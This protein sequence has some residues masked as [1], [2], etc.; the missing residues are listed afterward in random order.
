[1]IGFPLPMSFSS[2]KF[3]QDNFYYRIFL[4]IVAI[5]LFFNFMNYLAYAVNMI[6]YP[7][8]LDVGEGLIINRSWLLSRG[9]NIYSPID[10]EPYFV[11]NY[12]PL[13]ETVLAVLVKI[14]GPKIM[15][16]RVL[17]AGSALLCGYFIHKIVW[18]V[19]KKGASSAVAGLLFFMS[20]WLTS[21]SVLCRI[22]VFA[23]MFV[24]AGLSFITDEDRRH[25]R[26]TIILSGLCFVAALFSRQSMIAAPAACAAAYWFCREDRQRSLKLF[27]SCTVGLAVLIGVALTVMT[28]GE[29]FRHSVLYTMG[30]YE[31]HDFVRW[32]KEYL[33][34]HGM[35]TLVSVLGAVFITS[36]KSPVLSL[37]W[38]F[39]LL[40]TLT[41]GKLGASINYF[42]E[43]WSASCI[44]TGL[45]LSHFENND[46]APQKMLIRVG[47]M[48]VIAAQ[49]YVFQGRIDFTV[50]SK[51]YRQ[52]SEDL[53]A[54]IGRAPGEVLSEYTGYTAQNGKE[55]I[56]QSFSMAQL[57]LEGKWDEGPILDDL[58]KQ[59]FAL[60][61]LTGVGMEY[62]RWTP[63]FKQ[64]VERYY[65]QSRTFPCFELSYYHHTINVHYVFEPRGPQDQ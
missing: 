9:E 37:F 30:T 2:Q 8:D 46:H 60:I 65:K 38:M 12:T 48:G 44:L 62:D 52:A 17:S 55:S 27:L 13:F 10:R 24:L 21:W 7:Y 54:L 18:N 23:L 25:D 6:L 58:K 15:L 26:G 34:I 42:L 45:V 49:L 22:D 11:M 4:W 14:F 59:R 28:R 35:M 16:G 32:T 39:S 53:S 19:S 40:I 43:F 47:V 36:R 63:R 1:M 41:A 3:W 5:Y 50:P 61:I 33:N 57:A 64:A 56:Y 20:A 51:E 29:F 31:F